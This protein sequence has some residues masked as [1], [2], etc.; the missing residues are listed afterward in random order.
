MKY[1][2]I[3]EIC[4]NNKGAIAELI[5]G[6]IVQQWYDLLNKIIEQ[7]VKEHLAGIKSYPK[8]PTVKVELDFNIEN[9]L[10][11]VPKLARENF[12]FTKAVEKTKVIE[13]SLE[14]N[15]DEELK[16]QIKKTIIVRNLL[17]HNQGIVRDKDRKQT[18]TNSIKLIDNSCQEKDFQTDEKVEITIYKLFRIKQVFDRAAKKLILD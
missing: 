3:F 6:R 18:G 17:E 13:T 10:E 5:Y 1:Q 7:I 11:E 4:F 16:Q 2:K 9:F 14:Q 8:I 12:D 15:L